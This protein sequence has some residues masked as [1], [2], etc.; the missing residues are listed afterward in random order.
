MKDFMSSPLEIGDIVAAMDRKLIPK[1][2]E[3]ILNNGTSYQPG[4]QVPG[5]RLGQIIKFTPKGMRIRF[6]PNKSYGTD[7]KFKSAHQVILVSADYRDAT[8]S[9]LVELFKDS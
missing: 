1:G 7:E 3:R 2:P 5:L 4:Q 9:L 6:M 8:Q